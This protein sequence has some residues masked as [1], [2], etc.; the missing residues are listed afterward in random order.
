MILCSCGRERRKATLY[1]RGFAIWQSGGCSVGEGRVGMVNYS[2]VIMHISWA[3]SSEST[4]APLQIALGRVVSSGT[5]HHW[6]GTLTLTLHPWNTPI[7]PTREE[8]LNF[9]ALTEDELDDVCDTF[10]RKYGAGRF[11][12]AGASR[13]EQ[14]RGN[15]KYL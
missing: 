12:S 13:K 6:N 1:K 9:V 11:S 2:T 8:F 3:Q 15:G 4:K 7:R 14:A 5:K 10:R